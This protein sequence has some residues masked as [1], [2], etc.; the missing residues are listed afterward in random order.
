MEAKFV[1]GAVV[2][3]VITLFYTGIA[4]GEPFGGGKCERDPYSCATIEVK[5]KCSDVNVEYSSVLVE[6]ELGS[7]VAL[8]LPSGKRVQCNYDSLVDKDDVIFEA[9]EYT[10]WGLVK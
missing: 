8:E 2:L 10:V 4:H 9:I 3:V 5:L 6:N 1:F 7:W